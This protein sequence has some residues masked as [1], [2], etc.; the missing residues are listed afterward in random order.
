MSKVLKIPLPPSLLPP[1]T[2]T[3]TPFLGNLTEPVED[4]RDPV[5]EPTHSEEES[6]HH[7]EPFRDTADVEFRYFIEADINAISCRQQDAVAEQERSSLE[8]T[9][10]S[11]ANQPPLNVEDCVLLL[12][13]SEFERE[14]LDGRNIFGSY[15]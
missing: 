2:P 12:V 6:A 1:P 11:D 8:M 3:P 5:D 14:R 13:Q 7:V 10:S 15:F 9:A 4:T